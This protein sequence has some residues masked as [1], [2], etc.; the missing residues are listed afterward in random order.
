[1]ASIAQLSDRDIPTPIVVVDALD[2]NDRGTEF[3]EELLR[4]IHAGHLAG[5]KF[6]ITSRPDPK[7]VDICKSYPPSAVASKSTPHLYISA[8]SM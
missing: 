8:L 7:I 6:L 3:L 4:V 5:T 1:V 2:E